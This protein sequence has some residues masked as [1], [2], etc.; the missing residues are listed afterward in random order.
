MKNRD[1]ALNLS[2]NL[3]FISPKAMSEYLELTVI[4]ASSNLSEIERLKQKIFNYKI[5]E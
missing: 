3:G 2:E 4:V 5:D 1:L